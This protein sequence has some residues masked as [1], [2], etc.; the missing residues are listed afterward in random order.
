MNSDFESIKVPENPTLDD[1][2]VSLHSLAAVARE[3]RQ[4]AKGLREYGSERVADRIALIAVD[5]EAYRQILDRYTGAQISERLADAQR[6]TFNL[7]RG[8]MAGI[9]I[10]DK[11]KSA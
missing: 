6:S 5:V 11:P 3:L 1:A 4:I 10:G 2:H 8:V 9:E 7:V